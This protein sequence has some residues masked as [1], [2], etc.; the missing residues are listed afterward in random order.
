[1]EV[2]IERKANVNAADIFGITP[3]HMAAEANA[4]ECAK[5]LINSGSANINVKV[6]LLIPFLH[7]FSTVRYV[8]PRAYLALFNQRKLFRNVK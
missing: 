7:V 6:N 1:M 3:L 5:I 4:T 2:L 8:L